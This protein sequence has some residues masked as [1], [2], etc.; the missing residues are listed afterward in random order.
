[1]QTNISYQK[2]TDQWL[3]GAGEQGG[4]EGRDDR[5]GHG[6]F[7]GWWLFSQSYCGGRFTA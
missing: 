2:A 1:M 6:N 7:G 5:E 3:L 4:G